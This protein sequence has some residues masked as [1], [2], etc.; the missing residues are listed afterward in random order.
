M[1]SV[2]LNKKTGSRE[3][4]QER[5]SAFK[6]LY[7]PKSIES[8]SLQQNTSDL[9]FD[10]LVKNAGYKVTS[11]FLSL[12]SFV[13]ALI[14]MFLGLSVN[15]YI[16]ILLSIFLFYLPIYFLI[17]KSK[18]RSKKFNSEYPSILLSMS[19]N[20]KAGLTVY[21]SLERSIMLL[22]DDSDV[23]KE[24]KLF[25]DKISRGVP[26][27]AAVSQFAQTIDL[28]ELEL[29]RRAFSLVIVHGLSLIHI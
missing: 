3:V 23:K 15:I 25:L 2:V 22:P 20:M 6:N 17:S 19:S 8:L 12:L 4:S 13:L 14:G 18:D 21:S 10:K 24:V 9:Y 26:K 29:F 16:G 7:L 27:E 1:I 5:L 11:K 28:P